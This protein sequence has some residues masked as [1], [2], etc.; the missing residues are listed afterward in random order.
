[1]H[2]SPSSPRGDYAFRISFSVVFEISIVMPLHHVDSRNDLVPKHI[3]PSL[4][5]TWDLGGPSIFLINEDLTR[6]GLS[7][8]VD[9]GLVDLDPAQARFV[10]RRAGAIA[11][12]NIGQYRPVRVRPSIGT[13]GESDRAA[14]TDSCRNCSRGRVLVADDVGCS[15]RA[16]RD[17]AVVEVLRVPIWN[18][19][20]AI[21][22]LERIVLRERGRTREERINLKT[23]QP[24]TLGKLPVLTLS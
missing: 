6:P 11:G 3:I 10:D 19:E 20:S 9:T 7:A 24:A 18:E 13:P 8:I 2:H 5:R 4:Q 15:I 14:S 16:G 21:M 12:G 17:E 1:V 23:H 22:V